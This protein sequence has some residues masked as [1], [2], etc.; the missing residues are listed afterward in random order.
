[1]SY[2]IAELNANH[3]EAAAGLAMAAYREERAGTP[4]LPDENYFDQFG[5]MLARMID[6]RLGIVA[7]D[8]HAVVGF[9][10][11]LTP[12][13]NHF[14]T[15]L[16]T[17]CP[18]QAH[19]A[20]AEDRQYLSSLLYQHAAAK[21][22]AQGIYS[23]SIAVYGHDA[24]TRNALFWNGFGMR[25]VEAIRSTEPM[26]L[27][28]SRDAVFSEIP[29]PRLHQ[30][31][32]F[33]NLLETALQASPIFI[34]RFSDYDAAS[35]RAE[36]ERRH[37]RYFVAFLGEVSI[38]FLEIAS[39]G[40]NFVGQG[41]GMINI[42]G[43]YIAPAYRGTGVFGQMLAWLMDRLREEGYT[44]CGVDYEAFNP[45]ARGGWRKYFTDYV[46]GLAR[47]IDERISRRPAGIPTG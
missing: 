16:G 44:R 30:V 23:H 46:Y 21:W 17:F 42:R 22:V 37:S 19:G 13:A 9:I 15:S 43:A 38:G 34:P 25:T 18:V 27:P 28:G 32:S 6:D 47:R 45:Q 26:A 4:I 35:L 24:A 29:A 11:C 8:G 33:K 36:A 39:R 20:I 7:L 12:W 31:V 3:I 2:G 41:S 40:V 5:N 10:T 1:M 14:G